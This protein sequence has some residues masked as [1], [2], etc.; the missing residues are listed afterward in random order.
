MLPRSGSP[1]APLWFR[2]RKASCPRNMPRPTVPYCASPTA[3]VHAPMIATGSASVSPI[4]QAPSGG[5]AVAVPVRLPVPTSQRIR[6][7]SR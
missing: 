6:E 5:P 1:R 7:A 3:S 2:F 4:R